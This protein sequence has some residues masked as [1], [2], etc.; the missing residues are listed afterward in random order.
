M[1]QF[2]YSVGK[3]KSIPEGRRNAARSYDGDLRQRSPRDHAGS[4]A[5]RLDDLKLA[6][7]LGSAEGSGEI[8]GSGAGATHIFQAR[9]ETTEPIALLRPI[10]TVPGGHMV[11]WDAYEQTADV[12]QAFLEDSRT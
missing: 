12:L 3:L 9:W 10:V 4:D 2:A 11:F 6:S 7:P 8:R 1:E 5:L